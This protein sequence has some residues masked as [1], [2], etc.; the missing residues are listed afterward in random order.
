MS[1][2][3]TRTAFTYWC[4]FNWKSKT[5]GNFVLS[6]ITSALNGSELLGS[7][8]G[9]IIPGEEVQYIPTRRLCGPQ[10]HSGPFGGHINLS[11]L[12][13]FDFWD[14]PAHS[15]FSRPSAPILFKNFILG[16]FVAYCQIVVGF[17]CAVLRNLPCQF[18]GLCFL[19]YFIMQGYQ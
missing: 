10:S 4:S 13:E 9:R 19:I 18:W 16:S 2:P 8:P 1:V 3:V 17:I 14:R 11:P 7:G 5:N 6:I 15:L 12:Q